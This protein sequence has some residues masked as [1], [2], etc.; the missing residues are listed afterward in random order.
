[1]CEVARRPENKLRNR[2]GNIIA[3]KW[4]TYH[5][6]RISMLILTDDHTRVKLQEKD[7]E[8]GSDYINANFIDVS[9][10]RSKL[11]QKITL[12]SY[13]GL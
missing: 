10:Y 9:A 12:I 6:F 4:H 7:E 2:Y 8:T 5:P 13:T 11:S 1:M 3:C